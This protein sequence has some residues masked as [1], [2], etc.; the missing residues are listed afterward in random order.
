TGEPLS[1]PR[2]EQPDSIARGFLAAHP[3]MFGLNRSQILEMKLKNEDNDQGTTFLNY[4]QMIDGVSVF[5]GQVQFAVNAE[6]QVL[7]I[8]EGLVIPAAGIDTNPG[9]PESEGIQRAFLFAGR[10]VPASFET[11]EYRL[12]K[13]DRAVYQNPLGENHENIIS[14]MRIM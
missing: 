1:A 7:S 8:N 12:A 10:Q 2:S 4:E 3:A 6:G 9:L 11:M 5:Q 14:E 13:G